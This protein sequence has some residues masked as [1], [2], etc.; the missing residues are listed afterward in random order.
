VERIWILDVIYIFT[1]KKY[2]KLNRNLKS[3]R[4]GEKGRKLGRYDRVKS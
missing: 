3:E 4:M 2:E 1:E